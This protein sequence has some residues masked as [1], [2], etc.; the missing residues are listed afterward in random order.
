MP[1]KTR[2]NPNQGRIYGI[3]GI[4]P[5][6]NKMEGGGREPHIALPAICDM[7]CGAGLDI[8]DTAFCLKA[9]FDSGLSGRHK[10]TNGVAVPVLTPSRE[11]KRQN[12]R[13][14]KENGEPMF[15]LTGRDRHGVMVR[16]TDGSCVYAVW[17]EKY[18]CYVAIRKLTPRECFRL[19][20]WN[21]IYF[22][23][24]ALVNSDSQL[25]KQA[26]N[27]VTVPVIR[28]VAER[29]GKNA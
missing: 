2:D 14:F 27:G 8:R 15:T 24:A 5:C 28:A 25:Y 11:K 16:L 7:S 9:R 1:T 21:D 22:D 12:G 20:G 3:K 17:N 26:G 29:I 10:E 18:G 4:A 13:R 6:L 19:Q 23:R